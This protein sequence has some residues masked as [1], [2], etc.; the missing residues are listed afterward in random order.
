MGR[1]LGPLQQ[2]ILV[3]AYL[4]RYAD[5]PPEDPFH[6]GVWVVADAN[7]DKIAAAFRAAEFIFKRLTEPWRYGLR[8]STWWDVINVIKESGL[9]GESHSPIPG[10]LDW[11][12]LRVD[13]D[14]RALNGM[15]AAAGLECLPPRSR[16]LPDAD[17]VPGRY[18]NAWSYRRF[19]TLLE[20]HAFR[21]DMVARGFPEEHVITVN[22]WDVEQPDLTFAECLADLF[23]FRAHLRIH[24]DWA[25]ERRLP[26]GCIFDRA[27]IGE[28]SYRAASVA[29]AKALRGLEARDLVHKDASKRD[30][31]ESSAL[32]ITQ[33]GIEEAMRV[34]GNNPNIIQ[35]VTHY[36]ELG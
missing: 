24:A 31:W 26:G 23:G 36:R 18:V 30:A 16:R 7:P 35:G 5:G 8:L 27:A 12:N 1:G 10:A 19:D 20:A 28:K 6:P 17:V 14:I 32:W 4:N 2:K 34:R 33:K 25:R 15:L 11:V 3:M 22:A 9:Y 13:L 29:V 21:D